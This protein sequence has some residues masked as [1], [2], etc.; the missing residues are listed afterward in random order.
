MHHI[1]MFQTKAVC[2]NGIRLLCYVR[3]ICMMINNF[4]IKLIK[5]N[6]M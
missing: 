2:L 6:F 4:F 1:K 5:F 3:I